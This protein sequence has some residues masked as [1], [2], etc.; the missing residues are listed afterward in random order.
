MFSC[1]SFRLLLC[2]IAAL[3]WELVLIRWIG[4]CVRI[5]AYYS[6]F[7]LI[8]AFF[9]L[10]AGALFAKRN[11]PLH[12]YLAPVLAINVC[13]GILLSGFM[14]MNP[15]SPTEYIWLGGVVGVLLA[16]HGQSWI[17]SW[18]ILPLVY[19]CITCAFFI[20]GQWIG[21]LFK[22]LPP[23]KAY[24]IE[25]F[26]SLMGIALFAVLSYAGLSPVIWFFIGFLLLLPILEQKFTVYM[27]AVV[28]CIVLLCL[29][30][31]FAQQFT[32][33]PYYRIFIDPIT[34]IH[35]KESGRPFRFDR[36]VGQSLTVN[37]DYHQMILDLMPNEKDH[38]FL[39]S[40]RA[41]YE[42]PYIDEKKLPPG[43]ILIVGAGTGND[44]SAALRRTRRDIYAV[45]IDPVIAE[46]GKKLHPEKPYQNNRVKLITADARSFFQQ[47][48]QRFA[49]IVFGFLD[50][51]TLLSSFSSLR[52]DNYVY[53]KESFRQARDILLPGG[54]VSLS[55]ASNRTWMH[56]RIVLLLEQAFGGPTRLMKEQGEITYTNGIVYEI[57]KLPPFEQTGGETTYNSLPDDDWPFFYLQYPN[58]PTHYIPFIIV[59]VLFGFASLLILPPHARK[60]RL[61]YFFL[62][63]A[64][65]LLETSN[66]VS[67][68]LLYGSTWYV[69][70][71]VFSG[72]LVLILLGNITAHLLPKI[73]L[74]FIFVLLFI[75]VVIAYMIPI[76]S[77][78]AIEASIIRDMS[79]VIIF[80]GPVYFAGIVFAALIKKETNLYQ[81]YGSNIL[82]AVI[83]GA[84]E[85][86]SLLFGFKF[87]LGV[88]LVF[89]LLTY[90]LLKGM[91]VRL[92]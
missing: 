71:L 8:A 32:W 53:T 68:S 78:L 82:G 10:G 46:L 17:S 2:G 70:I 37:N 31:P 58:I 60:I 75:T 88:V 36:V 64:F 44:V 79:A 27:V 59:V 57:Y 28:S 61:P 77:L 74:D 48:K 65:F 9:G 12:R 85:Y 30:I 69:N 86:L 72:I 92:E 43:P 51:H 22:E 56:E 45:E 47:T 66:V 13:L 33:S 5:V 54:K 55:F 81:A 35:E 40:W 7:V 1:A 21:I 87:L 84:C 73:H 4:S 63:A 19:I 6:N 42:A 34:N 3:Y 50:S 20:F 83:G 26:G 52:L 91:R 80:L 89:Y 49:L 18:V 39:Q 38:L 90:M 24:S 67:L 11:I 62:G 25:V 76:S 16:Q 23:L 41:L 15:E 14:H 29:A